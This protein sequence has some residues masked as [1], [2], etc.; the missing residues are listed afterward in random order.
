MKYVIN[1]NHWEDG[2]GY[3]YSTF[4]DNVPKKLS[5]KELRDSY[6]IY[7]QND[8]DKLEQMDTDGNIVSTYRPCADE[9]TMYTVDDYVYG[10]PGDSDN[11]SIL[12]TMADGAVFAVSL[13]N[14]RDLDKKTVE[15]LNAPDADVAHFKELMEVAEVYKYSPIF[16]NLVY[17]EAD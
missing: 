17:K 5:P 10:E 12:M 6:A 9:N 15:A 16:E 4:I 2:C 13:A 8:G 14:Y 3:S 1:Y 11:K 7:I